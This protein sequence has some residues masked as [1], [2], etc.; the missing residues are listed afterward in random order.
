AARAALN[1]FG[2]M[3][4]LIT[5]TFFNSAVLASNFSYLFRLSVSVIF[6]FLTEF[7]RYKIVIQYNRHHPAAHCLNAQLS[8]GSN[9]LF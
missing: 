2:K 7:W 4:L 5:Y 1:L 6:I 8:S 9:T 3:S